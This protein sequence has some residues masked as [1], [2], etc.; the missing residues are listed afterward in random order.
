LLIVKE[1][2]LKLPLSLNE[3]F[4]N[5][6]PMLS[7]SSNIQQADD[8]TGSLLQGEEGG[9]AS[10]PN[11]HLTSIQ[12]MRYPYPIFKVLIT[13]WVIYAA[14]YVTLTVATPKCSIGYFIVFVC[15]YPPLLV[16]IYWSINYLIKQQ[17]DY[18]MT[19]LPGDIEFQNLSYLPSAAAFIIGESI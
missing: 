11:L 5:I 2:D 10:E 17:R 4:S 13:V 18:P 7:T 19:I 14:V 9:G 15:T 1:K 12:R 16:L 6:N 3:S 8:L